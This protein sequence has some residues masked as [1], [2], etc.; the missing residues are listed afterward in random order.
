LTSTTVSHHGASNLVVFLS[1][2]QK[3]CSNRCLPLTAGSVLLFGSVLG[4]GCA[5]SQPLLQ[6]AHV[7]PKGIVKAGVGLSGQLATGDVSQAIQ[8]ARE[9]TTTGTAVQPDAN[10][11]YRKGAAALASYAPGVAPWVGANVGLGYNSDAGL[12][13]TAR[14]LRVGVRHAFQN[15]HWAL[16]IGGG[17]QAALSRRD[18]SPGQDLRGLSLE[19][20]SGYGFDVPIVA[21]WQSDSELV[22]I[23]WGARMGYERLGGAIG[24]QPQPNEPLPVDGSPPATPWK[25]TRWWG[26]GLIGLQIGFR[27]LFLGLEL[28]VFYHSVNAEIDQDRPKIQGFTISPGGAIQGSF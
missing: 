26:G 1:Y 16:S 11:K 28:D 27:H 22:S 8:E 4:T 12:L 18:K 7:V 2:L 14:S 6:P 13:Y 19:E 20:V 15:D 25:A 17:A 3:R 21:G 24:L 5:G 9:S 23:W 10:A